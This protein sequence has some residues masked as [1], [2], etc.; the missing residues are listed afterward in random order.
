MLAAERHLLAIA[1]VMPPLVYPRS[2]Q[3]SRALKALHVRGWDIDVVRMEPDALPRATRDPR[4]ASIY[5]DSYSDHPIDIHSWARLERFRRAQWTHALNSADENTWLKR[6]SRQTARLLKKYRRAALVTFAQPW[7]NHAV[8]LEIACRRPD[9]PWIAHFSDPWVDSPYYVNQAPERI[10]QWRGEERA[11]VERADALVFVNGHTADL[12]MSKYP[13]MYRD[14]VFIV[15]HGYDRNLLSYIAPPPP[16]DD[17]L[18]IVHTGNLYVGR[19]PDAL[20]RAIARLKQSNGTDETPTVTFVGLTSQED[21]RLAAELG[22]EDRTRFLGLMPFLETLQIA[23]GADILVAIDA[24]SELNLFLPSKIVDYFLLNKPILG[25]TPDE[26]ATADVLRRSGHD[27]VSPEDDVAIEHA[28]QK[29]IQAWKG[30]RLGERIVQHEVD[31]FD[32]R[33]TSIEFERAIVAAIARRS[34][35]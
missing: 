15:P 7:I 3:L 25:L 2:I 24:P 13:A 28:L 1:S 11:V 20:L 32:I 14:K 4:L 22:I 18:Q 19:R 21:Q 27:V 9:L 16:S 30:R 10:E 12:V 31:A 34:S 6:A 33:N 8:G 17:R 23:A 26:G 5:K 29:L 35:R